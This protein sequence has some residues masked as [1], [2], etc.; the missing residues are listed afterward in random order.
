MIEG[1]QT[2]VVFK[3]LGQFIRNSTTGEKSDV[4]LW[5]AILI[6]NDENRSTL[7]NAADELEQLSISRQLT[8]NIYFLKDGKYESVATKV[9]YT[10]A[11]ISKKC[12]KL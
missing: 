7:E 10:L 11:N 8:S 12:A 3:Y 2:N 9:G 4:E 5:G 6:N 1:I